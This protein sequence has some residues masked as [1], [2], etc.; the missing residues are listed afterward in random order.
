MNYTS[1]YYHANINPSIT[2]NPGEKKLLH[3]IEK[4]NLAKGLPYTMDFIDIQAIATKNNEND[5]ILKNLLGSIATKA[6][7]IVQGLDSIELF[8]ECMDIAIA[9]KDWLLNLIENPPM[10]NEKLKQAFRKHVHK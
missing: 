3:S 6:I 1:T 2:Y 5:S 4:F 10:P 8:K 9:D 7:A